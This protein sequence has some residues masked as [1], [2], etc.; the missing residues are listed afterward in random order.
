MGSAII[1]TQ[2]GCLLPFLIVF[3]FFF[4]WIFLGW[5]WWL[6]SEGLLVL[7][8]F[9][10]SYIM[11][12]KLTRQSGRSEGVIDVEGRIIDEKKKLK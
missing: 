9:L 5:R 2:A 4:G 1:L 11:L 6:I 12:R 7:L 10:T 3:N 8:F